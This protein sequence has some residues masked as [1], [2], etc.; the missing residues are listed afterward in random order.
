MLHSSTI[1]Q[2]LVDYEGYSITCMGFLPTVI[3]IMVIW[4]KFAFPS[5]L[6]HWFLRC[7]CTLESSL[8]NKEIQPV[9][10]KGNQ[11][12][13]FIGRADV[14]A[15]APIF[16]PPDVKNWLTGKDP[17]AGNNQ[18]QEEKGTTEGEMVGWH[19]WLDGHEF[20]QALGVGDGQGGLVSRLSDWTDVYSYHLLLDHIQ[21]TLIDGPNSPGSYAIL[22][23]ITSD[24][25]FMTRHIHNGQQISSF[26]CWCILQ[27]LPCLGH[28]K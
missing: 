27:L 28:C 20:E 18:G 22:F 21:F 4:I 8:D 15:E 2:T 3:D 23:F 12:W 7:W 6:L 11:S 14:E 17:D 24:F 19:H 25:A 16:W 13:I 5:I 10:P 1:F 26:I 9:H